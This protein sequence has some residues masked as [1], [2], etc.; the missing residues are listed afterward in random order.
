MDEAHR[1]MAQEHLAQAERA[2]EIGLKHLAR[3]KQIVAAFSGVG[4]GRASAEA[5]LKT[6]L[7][8]QALHEEH[9][10]RLRHELGLDAAGIAR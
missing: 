9:R 7:E 8:S 3:Q 10:D 2:V 4:P 5:L 6:M 1:R